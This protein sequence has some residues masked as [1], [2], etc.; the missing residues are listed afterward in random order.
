MKLS[1]LLATIG[2]PTL[3]RTLRSL[4]QQ[5][6]QPGDEVMILTDG[7]HE[8]VAKLLLEENFHQSLP[9]RHLT[10]T[11]GPHKDWGHTPRNRTMHLAQGDFLC[12]FDDDDVALPGMI[13]SIHQVLGAPLVHM[14]RMI[15]YKSQRQVWTKKGLLQRRHVS[16]QNV[17]HPNDPKKFGRWGSFYGGDAQFIMQTAKFYQGRVCFHDLITCVYKPPN[18]LSY[19][20]VIAWFTARPG[21]VPPSLPS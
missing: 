6:W 20:D 19:E 1:L 16:T 2:R 9:I 14:F 3:L 18:E 10:I 21:A 12:H 11:D 4:E 5:A 7:N 15:D 13:A 17:V 8:E